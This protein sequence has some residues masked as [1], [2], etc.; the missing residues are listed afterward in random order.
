MKLQI[1]AFVV[2]GAM[3]QSYLRMS[4]ATGPAM[5][6]KGVPQGMFKQNVQTFA[7]AKNRESMPPV[8]SSSQYK[9]DRRQMAALLTAGAIG[10]GR[11]AIAGPFDGKKPAAPSKTAAKAPPAAENK[12]T[13]VKLGNNQIYDLDKGS[14]QDRRWRI[15]PSLEYLNDNGQV[16]FRG[17][18]DD[19]ALASKD[20]IFVG[21]IDS[22]RPFP[23]VSSCEGIVI[24][25]KS[26]GYTGFKMNLGLG[27][28]QRAMSAYATQAPFT[29]PTGTYGEVKMPFS[30]FSPP[31]DAGMLKD[32]KRIVFEA[33]D[34]QG[35]AELSVTA[36]DAY[37]CKP[38]ALIEQDHED[39]T[40]LWYFAAAPLG[41][42][43]FFIT[44][45]RARKAPVTPPLFG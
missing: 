7:G 1:I 36:L 34:V 14:G 16:T 27:K 22:L 41:L 5:F 19:P 28:Q 31:P 17:N 37:G 45:S 44:R 6:S 39:T 38:V 32:V 10:M 4:P 15:V 43:A 24:N 9:L 8:E 21:T 42:L 11:E 40:F 13:L 2:T 29:A 3:A 30:S 33:S 23:D 25:A 20:D 12:I 26:N 18:L 35:D